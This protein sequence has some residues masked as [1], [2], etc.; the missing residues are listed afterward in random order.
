MMLLIKAK[1]IHVEYMGRDILEIDDLE[2]YDYDRIGLVG[3]NGAGKSTL[4]KLL[5]GE[6]PLPHGKI[7][8]EGHFSY[9]P[10]MDDVVVQEVKDYTL[11]GKLGVDALEVEHMSGGE[12]SRLKIAQALS[13]G[14]HGIFADEPTSHLDRDGID[15]LIDQLKYYSGA[16]L[17]ISH[18]RYFLDQ[19]VD[20]VWELKDGKITEYWGGYSEYLAQ[21][22]EERQSEA[23]QYKQFTAERDRLERAITEKQ[24][25]A[26]KMDQKAKGTSRKSSSESGGR[27]GHQKTVGGKQK[28]L[29]NAAKNMERRI[30]SLG[31]V[32]PPEATRAVHFRLSQALELH[33]PFPITGKEISKRLGDKVIFEKA[34][35]QFPLGA[36]IALTGANGTGKTTLFKMI[37]DREDGIS[38]SPKAEIGYFAQNGYKFNRNQ[39][40]MEFMLE[41]CDYQVSEIRAVLASMGFSQNDVRKELSMLSGGEIIKLQLAKMLL[42][43]YNILLMD[44]PSNFLDLPAVEALERL[45]KNYAGTII[46]ISHDFRLLENVADVV[47]EIEDEKIVRKS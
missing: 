44:E 12:E 37:L 31:D 30:E 28:K 22:E 18:D 26:R 10:Q 5:L 27:L 42:G 17:L 43:R 11:M 1:D 3:A 15:F 46:F 19:V 36:K 16:L 13:G 25:Q 6:A 14:V 20:K 45:M 24:N 9:I 38:L 8:R 35:F 2:L 41:N 7:I 40:I 33:N 23:A 32:K 47:Y 34:S 21:K 4:L 39:G 29:H